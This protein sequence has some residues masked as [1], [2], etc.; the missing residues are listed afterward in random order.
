MRKSLPLLLAV[1]LG[2]PLAACRNGEK[3]EMKPAEENGP[4]AEEPHGHAEEAGHEEGEAEGEDNLVRIAPEMLRDL[5]L[6]TAR[7]EAREAKQRVAALGE[8]KVNENAYAAVSP[9]IPARVVVLRAEPGQGVRAGQVLAE[10][11]SMELG[12]ARADHESAAARAELAEQTLERKRGLAAERIVSLGELQEAQAAAAGAQAELRAARASLAAFGVQG[13]RAGGGDPSRFALHSPIGG[14]VIERTAL[15]GETAD[16]ARPLFRVADLSRLWLVVQA[17]ERDAVRLT[18]GSAV[19]VTFAALPGRT[20]RGTVARVG[21]EVA[22]ESRTVPVRIDLVNEGRLLRPGMSATAW[23]PLSDSAGT[24][25]AVP[26]AALQRIE[27]GWSVFLPRGEG[28]FEVRPVGRGRDLGGEIE[29]LSGL[30]AGTTVVVDGAFLLKAEADKAHGGG[31]HH[32][33]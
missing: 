27:E 33:H 4:A 24:V 30:E 31:E 23:L 21:G 10:L 9:P 26:A 29:I 11:Q 16:P 15:R 2:L 17:S 28:V 1:L 8:L 6:T 3:S 22:P 12:R 20:L 14:T 19:E 25:V 7:A 5:K 13:S 18:E 32:H